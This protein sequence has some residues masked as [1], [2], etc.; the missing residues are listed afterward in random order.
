[1][2]LII[3]L[4]GVITIINT[5]FRNF[6]LTIVNDKEIENIQSE[7]SDGQTWMN[8]KYPLLIVI[9]ALIW[10]VLSSSPEKFGNV[11]P[12]VSGIMAGIPTILKLLSYFKPG[13]SNN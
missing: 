12:I 7:I 10:F 2:C 13:T 9:G 6:I 3:K 8:Y 1:M 11:L 4:D 5:S